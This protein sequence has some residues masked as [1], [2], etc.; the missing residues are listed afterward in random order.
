MFIWTQFQCEWFQFCWFNTVS[1]NAIFIVYQ[2]LHVFAGFSFIGISKNIGHTICANLKKINSNVNLNYIYT[3][4]CELKTKYQSEW[5][6]FCAHQ[7]HVTIP[8]EWPSRSTHYEWKKATQCIWH[9]KILLH[10]NNS[11]WLFTGKYH[12]QVENYDTYICSNWTAH[13]VHT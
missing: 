13:G 2:S 4:K 11:L 5:V 6:V 9:V 8:I 1:A 7:F 3:R 12:K 10:L